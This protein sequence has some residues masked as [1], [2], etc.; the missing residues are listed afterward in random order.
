[1]NKVE[2]FD[3]DLNDEDLFNAV[4]TAL[5]NLNQLPATSETP[6]PLVQQ[7]E[8]GSSSVNRFVKHQTLDEFLR[9]QQNDNTRR[10]TM[11]DIKLFQS[12]LASKNESRFPQYIPPADLDDYISVF[13]LSVRKRDG[14]E[15]E[16]ATVRSFVSSINRHLIMN[17]YKFSIMTDAQFRRCREILAA[18]QKQLKSIG[19]GNRPMAADEITDDELETMYGKKVLS[20][21]SPSSL[22]YSLWLIC[23]LHFGMRPGKETHDLKWGDI[24]L[25][26]DVDGNE[27]IVFTQERQ[28]KTRIGSN[29]H[30]IRKTKPMHFLNSQTETL[31]CSTKNSEVSDQVECWKRTVPSF[32]Q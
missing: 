30:D 28:T 1:M 29:P 13:L 25:R 15:F 32:W 11:N 26:S 9:E 18:K 10:K 21:E 17:G 23:T 20:P 8:Q 24:D 31:W 16:P 5:F 6:I 3:T 22:I 14:T 7:N 2:N 27:Y 4:E 19:K 12:Y